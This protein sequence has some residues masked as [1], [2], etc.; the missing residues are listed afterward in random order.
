VKY[1]VVG[2]LLYSTVCAIIGALVKHD[3]PKAWESD[4]FPG[5]ILFWP[6]IL[7]LAGIVFVRTGPDRHTAP[8]APV[9]IVLRVRAGLYAGRPEHRGEIP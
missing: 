6:I 4:P 9:L 3:D 5:W 1:L 2:F 8:R 7:P